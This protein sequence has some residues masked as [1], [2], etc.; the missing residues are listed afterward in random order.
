M[1]ATGL[2]LGALLLSSGQRAPVDEARRQANRGVAL[3]EQFRFTEAAAAFEQVVRASPESAAGYI[4][5]G[6]SYFNERD[7]EKSREALEKALRA[8]ARTCTTI[9]ASSTSSREIPRR[10]RSPSRKLR[11]SIPRIR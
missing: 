5:L 9:S 4:N 7:F 2:F 3:L 8:R 1:K 6:I 10:R 11:R